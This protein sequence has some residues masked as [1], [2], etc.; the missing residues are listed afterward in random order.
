MSTPA[1]K[2]RRLDGA[3][4]GLHKPFRTPLKKAAAAAASA[5]DVR[6]GCTTAYGTID[7]NSN[8]ATTDFNNSSSINAEHKPSSTCL[9]HNDN[10]GCAIQ[11]LTRTHTQTNESSHAQPVSSSNVD[12]TGTGNSN[13]NANIPERNIP[14]YV[15]SAASSTV[16]ILPP[17]PTT[18][19]T[20]SL[21]TNPSPAPS[22][23]RALSL[24]SHAQS[25]PL[26]PSQRQHGH[27][28]SALASYADIRK[29]R[30]DPDIAAAQKEQRAL[31]Q[32]LRSVRTDVDVLEQAL[33]ITRQRRRQQQQ[34]Q[35]QQQQSNH[36]ENQD[37]TPAATTMTGDER[38]ESL[39]AKWRAASRQ[40][41]E[42]VYTGARERVDR[43]G[44][45]AAWRERE[46]EKA[47]H[48]QSNNWGWDTAGAART[49]YDDDNGDNDNDDDNDNDGSGEDRE[50]R[51]GNPAAEEEKGEDEEKWE[52]DEKLKEDEADERAL[53]E[54]AAGLDGD[55]SYEKN[56]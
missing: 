19:T 26:T 14:E 51:R 44:G 17:P 9:D 45:V 12:T 31:E 3:S 5:P 43:M 30:S 40:A 2:R 22:A 48:R 38:L 20:T 28:A 46:R 4:S 10:R 8:I 23:T 18:T 7:S 47:E 6:T 50:A 27:V 56:S 24:Q 55:V 33:R 1:S 13:G 35:Q 53:Q 32:R 49:G 11:G 54:A 41:A 37:G 21:L 25:S 15:L 29:L 52:Y 34:Q 36:P 39:I 42:E 16:T